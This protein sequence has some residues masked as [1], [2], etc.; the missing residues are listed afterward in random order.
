MRPRLVVFVALSVAV[1]AAA[2]TRAQMAPWNN[3]GLAGRAVGPGGAG[4]APRS[5]RH[6]GCRDG[7]HPADG[8]CRL[9]VHRARRA[10]GQSQQAGNGTRL[11]S[12]TDDNDPLSTH[13]R[14]DGLSANRDVR[15]AA[16]PDRADVEPGADPLHVREAVAR[17]LDRRPRA[18]DQS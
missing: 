14:S 15:A 13:G 9:A 12:V 17:H 11:V 4:A 7:R 6:L 8:A 1:L 3:S 2:L 10:D 5:L 18:S 16:V